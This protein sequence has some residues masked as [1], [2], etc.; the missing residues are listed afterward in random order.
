[1]RLTLVISD[2]SMGGSQRVMSVLANYWANKDWQITLL[3]F[4]DGKEEPF[5]ELHPAINYRPLGIAGESFNIIQ[6]LANNFTRIRVLRQ[7]I[8]TSAPNS[9][10]SFLG[11]TNVISLIASLGLNLSVIISERSIPAYDSLSKKWACLMRWCYRKS[12]CLIVQNQPILEYFSNEHKLNIKLIPNPVTSPTDYELAPKKE[13][14]HT[15]NVLLAM[16]RLSKEKGF[17]LLL[18]ALAQV[19]HKHPDWSLVI[20]GEGPQRASLE[21]LRTE[22][23]LQDKVYFPGLTKQ[24]YDK[25]KQAD[26]FVLSSRYEGF[27]NVL[28]EAM[29]CGLPV[30]S[31]DCPSGPRE[32][33]RNGFDGILVPPENVEALATA[34]DKLIDDE[35]ERKRLAIR[36]PEVVERFGLE[37]VMLMWE[38]VIY[39]SLEKQIQ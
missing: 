18:K 35:E 23:G 33:I 38:E 7:A 14:N 30:I 5:Y 32:I 29:A 17:D 15:A 27:P 26:L 8:K 3:T 12:F 25:L 37:K 34:I 4:D 28:C 22:L 1:M 20:W 19:A 31:F 2:L 6:G 16:G 9:V 39:S 24:S 36:A 13:S 11:Q 21:K 10:I